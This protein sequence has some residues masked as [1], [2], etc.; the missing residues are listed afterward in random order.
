MQ[1]II[2][3]INEMSPYLLL[4]F[5]LAGVMKAFVPETLYKRYLS[6]NNFKSVLNATLIG[7]PLPLCSCGVLPTAMGLY[8]QG[9]SKGATTAFLIA[10]PQ[11]GVD[12]IIAT[13]SLM[14]LPF[15]ILRPIAAL[16][17]S[18]FG[19][20]LVNKFD[21]EDRVI[22]D[23]DNET[24][25]TK[26]RLSIKEKII[27]T[28]KFAYIEMM[29]DIGKW[30]IIGLLIA[31]AITVF[32]PESFF[33][34][35]SDNSL[36]SILF[37]LLFAIPMY[38]CATGS[39]PI[40]VALMLKG[41][42]PGTA[43]VMLMAGPAINFA[44]ILVLNKILGKKSL[45]IYLLSIIFCSI[46]F[47][48]IINNLLPREWFTSHLNEIKDCCISSTP[49][50][51][52]VCTILLF[53]LLINAFILKYFVKHNCNCSNS[54]CSCHGSIK[55]APTLSK[56]IIDG[57]KCNHCKAN[58]E[59]A[60]MSVNGVTNVSVDIVTGE[61]TIYGNFNLNEVIDSIE[62]LGFKVRNKDIQ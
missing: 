52:I 25:K 54:N 44:S 33:A 45:I 4:G 29:Q 7:I 1:E 60:I 16:V 13:V 8:K 50:F 26:E 41:L 20:V 61:T 15:A 5:L 37:V 23:N 31:G 11:T 21:K 9:A 34:L 22:I 51:N 39:I 47:A 53:I 27:T 2:N 59:N 30:L 38:L 57:M 14:G 46:T 3:L 42:S 32:V 43:L 35:F 12:S 17:T 28:F 18:I 24:I 10:T 36:L 58:A 6:N 55:D 48:L 40:A 56:I 49:I 62:K 19:G